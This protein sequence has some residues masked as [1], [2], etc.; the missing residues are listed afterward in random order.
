M[1][2]QRVEISCASYGSKDMRLAAVVEE[3]EPIPQEAV[4]WSEL[5]EMQ[6]RV[7]ASR[8]ASR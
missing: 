4:D 3:P 2:T 8:R 7:H 6:R 1:A 5:I